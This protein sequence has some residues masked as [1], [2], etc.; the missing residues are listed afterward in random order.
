MSKSES[1]PTIVLLLLVAVAVW[2]FN[3]RK[4][5]TVT[6]GQDEEEAVI[7][8]AGSTDI[9]DRL[10]VLA[11]TQPKELDELKWDPFTGKKLVV[12]PPPK[13][14]EKPKPPVQQVQAPPK[15]PPKPKPP[16]FLITYIGR[17]VEDQTYFIFRERGKENVIV[18]GEWVGVWRLIEAEE[19]LLTFEDE[20]GN[21][22]LMELGGGQ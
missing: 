18:V 16:P 2:G 4:V 11:K 9:Q 7:S 10:K 15:E 22:H 6:G 5:I 1:K 12:E 17:L 8:F 19:A 21:R 13:P 20:K 3:M 14:V